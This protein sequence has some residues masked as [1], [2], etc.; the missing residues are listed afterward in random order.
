MFSP[1][2]KQSELFLLPFFFVVSPDGQFVQLV[3]VKDSL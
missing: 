2:L 3:A 1:G